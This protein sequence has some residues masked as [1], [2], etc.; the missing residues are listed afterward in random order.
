MLLLIPKIGILDPKV[1][2]GQHHR[3]ARRSPD[4]YDGDVRPAAGR[5][6]PSCPSDSPDHPE[7]LEFL[8]CFGKYAPSL[9]SD[10]SVH[11]VPI[12]IA[13]NIIVCKEQN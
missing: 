12:I 5:R 11:G 9:T 4:R 8:G 6:R 3:L 10:L 2:V 7:G 13:F 1:V